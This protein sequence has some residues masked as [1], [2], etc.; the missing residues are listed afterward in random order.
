MIKYEYPIMEIIELEED[1]IVCA[2]GDGI[3]DGG[4]GDTGDWM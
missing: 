3:E 2:S 4:W 1:D